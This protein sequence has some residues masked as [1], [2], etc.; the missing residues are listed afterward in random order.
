MDYT[1]QDYGYADEFR[2][3]SN[4]YLK[5]VETWRE[6]ELPYYKKKVKDKIFGGYT[7][8]IAG[9]IV[10]YLIY[11]VLLGVVGMFYSKIVDV[12][13]SNPWTQWLTIGIIA[14]ITFFIIRFAGKRSIVKF[15]DSCH[16][17]IGHKANPFYH[18]LIVH[19]IVSLILAIAIAVV[20]IVL[21]GK[22]VS[23]VGDIA[24][25]ST[26]MFLPALIAPCAY[27][28]GS[29]AG[30]GEL[31]V[32]PIC[33]RY[34]TVY[35]VKLG[36]DFGTRKDGQHKEYDYKSERVGTK[37]T[38]TYYTDGST[39]SRSEGIYES[40]RYTEEYDD[41]SSLAKFAYLCKECSYV[42][43][44]IEEKQWKVLQDRYRG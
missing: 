11:A 7:M 12:L 39:S 19:T 41:F 24:V 6:T 20:C 9:A 36:Q 2:P 31:T 22:Q 1:D 34:N 26:F 30:I 15:V 28:L 29:I 18:K 27:F 16:G 3:T 13:S 25:L 32:C 8:V 17:E 14:V 10:A 38:T 43:E 40:V 33:G 21:V 44:T 37:T 5:V 4:K 23:V 35:K 42:E